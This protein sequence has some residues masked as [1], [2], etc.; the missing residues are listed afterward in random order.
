MAVARFGIE[1]YGKVE[2][3]SRIRRAPVADTSKENSAI[4]SRKAIGHKGF[5]FGVSQ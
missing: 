1:R 2:L 4:K 3:R 5:T